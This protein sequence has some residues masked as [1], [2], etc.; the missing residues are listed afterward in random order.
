MLEIVLQEKPVLRQPL[1]RLQHVH[2]QPQLLADFLR[3]KLLDQLVKPRV[4]GAA[5]HK[6]IH[7]PLEVRD[8]DAV[9]AEEG[10]LLHNH[11]GNPRPAVPVL[12]PL[13][14]VVQ[15]LRVDDQQLLQVAEQAVQLFV[16]N[17]GGPGGFGCL[18]SQDKV[19]EVDVDEPQDVDVD[20]L[21]GH[22]LTGYVEDLVGPPLL[23]V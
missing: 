2:T 6:A 9:E 7:A 1:D 21:R 16:G 23:G 22:E 20:L 19:P 12:H 17:D 13:L 5:G 3:L 18:G 11:V 15:E 14:E 4:L 10:A 8:V